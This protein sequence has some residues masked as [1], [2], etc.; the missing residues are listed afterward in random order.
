MAAAETSSEEP[1][2]PVFESAAIG[3]AVLEPDSQLRLANRSFREM[4]GYSSEELAQSPPHALSH[5]GDW[6]DEVLHRARL[7][8][9]TADT[10]QREHRLLHRDGHVVWTLLSCDL[11]R[12]A[13]GQPMHFFLQ[14]QDITRAKVAEAAHRDSEERARGLSRR[15]NEQLELLDQSRDAIVVQAMDGTIRYWS[16]GAQRMF[17]YARDQAM[18][19]T[20]E[21]LMGHGATLGPSATDDL[22]DKGEWTGELD[23]VDAGGRMIVVERRCCLTREAGGIPAGV[24]S[25]DTDVTERRRAEKEIVLLN[26]VLEQRIRKRT[27]ELEESNEDLRDFAYSLAHDLRA[28]LSSIDGFS[29]QLEL[30]LVEHLDEKSRHYLKRV[31]AGVRLMADLTDALLALADLSNTQLLHQNVDLSAVAHNIIERLRDQHPEREVAVV[32]EDTPRAQGDIR[33]L[34]D[35]MENLLG[36]AW[37]FTSRRGRAEIAFGGQSWPNGS[38]LYHVKDNGAGFDPEY[39]YKLFGPFQRLHTTNEFEGT[40]IGLAMVRKIVSRHGGRVWAESVPGEGASFFFTLN[41]H[42]PSRAARE[43]PLKAAIE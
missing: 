31:R 18:G 22:M 37:K 16:R 17:G 7:L 19:Q 36:N 34:T 9:G 26:N 14:V 12:D 42:A 23:C 33:L 8:A 6:Q 30:R 11:V 2:G 4:L 13:A 5:P 35:V 29:A 41:E 39:A 27:E 38:Y 43:A 40:G 25:V 20:F 3:M 10:Y 24:L 28:P 1:C 32:I 21:A 15:L